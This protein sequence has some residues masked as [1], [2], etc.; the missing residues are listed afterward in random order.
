MRDG[1]RHLPTCLRSIARQR[2]ERLR[3]QEL[4]IVVVDDGSTDET[5]AI[6][7]RWQ[8]RDE[9]IRVLTRPP[10]G[11][12]P[13]LNDA[14]DACRG[15][16]VA[17]MDADD[18]MLPWRLE[19]QVRAL[20]E[21]PDLGVV[22]CR[23]RCVPSAKIRGGFRHYEE[24]LNGLLEPEEIRRERFVESPVANP[25]TTIRRSLVE[26][27]L[28]G[29]LVYRDVEWAEDY[30]FWLRLLERG[31]RF[32]KV[33]EVLHFWRD[34]PRRLTRSDKRYSRENFLACKSHF[35]ARGPLA[36]SQEGS[37][38]FLVWGAGQTGKRLAKALAQE[39]RRPE[40]FLDI[41]PKKVGRAPYGIPVH[42]AGEIGA[43]LEPGKIVLVAVSRRGAR[44]LIR[45]RLAA[46]KLIEGRDAYFCA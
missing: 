40:A 38:P 13:S 5:P 44:E 34:H 41:D 31:V 20:D 2:Y 3:P 21:D 7:R 25:T 18:L 46:E 35:L 22:S 45:P 29:E 28:G 12:V 33:D 14:H 43:L 6:L 10:R 16:Y 23:V 11:V 42:D 36:S 30:D 19:R 15:E 1:A 17:R 9:R 4:E 26:E 27:A 8:R 24:W 39:G 37:P 32:A